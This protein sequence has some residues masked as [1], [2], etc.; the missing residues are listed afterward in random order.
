MNSSANICVICGPKKGYRYSRAALVMLL[1]GSSAP[2]LATWIQTMPLDRNIGAGIATNVTRTRLTVLVFNLTII[3]FLYSM[4]VT[5]DASPDHLAHLSTSVAL[6]AGFCLTLLGLWLL[7]LSQDWDAEGLSRPLPFTLGAMTNYLA[8]SQTVTAF[9]HEFMLV[10]TSEV[11]ASRSIGVDGAASRLGLDALGDT[12]L[13]VLLVMG[14][15]VWVLITYIAPVIAV[16]DSPV[17]GDRRWLLAG[18]YL[19]LQVPIYWVYSRAW[20]LEYAPADQPAGL[21]SQFALQFFQPLL[22][23]R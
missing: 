7:L 23:F 11:K 19:A 6:F 21:L 18:Y 12:T 3:T 15:A 4:L 2:A 1:S 9:M 22:W 17:R 5:G 20:Q 8:L 10:V 16:L 14:S 13:L